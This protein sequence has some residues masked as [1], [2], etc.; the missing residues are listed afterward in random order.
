M[1]SNFSHWFSFLPRCWSFYW[2]LCSCFPGS[3]AEFDFIALVFLLQDWALFFSQQKVAAFVFWKKWS[4]DVQKVII[5]CR[6]Y[7]LSSS[8][9]LSHF[10]LFSHAVLST[11]LYKSTFTLRAHRER[12][13]IGFQWKIFQMC[14]GGWREEKNIQV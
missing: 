13:E 10:H 11:S 6:N 2:F 4:W 1:F 12:R 8:Y 3:G 9:F 5:K 7:F 14:N